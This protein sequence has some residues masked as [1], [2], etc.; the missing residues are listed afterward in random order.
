MKREVGESPTRSR[1]CK[2]VGRLEKFTVFLTWEG[3]TDQ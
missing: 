3:L 1:H 2:R